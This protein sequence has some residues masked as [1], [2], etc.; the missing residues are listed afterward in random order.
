MRLTLSARLSSLNRFLA[1]KK[2]D[3]HSELKDVLSTTLRFVI[4]WAK[5][6]VDFHVPTEDGTIIFDLRG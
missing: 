6:W 2:S 5:K 1:T 4:I 3:T